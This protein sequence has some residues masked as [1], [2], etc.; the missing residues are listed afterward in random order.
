MADYNCYA[1]RMPVYGPA[2]RLISS[3]T[4]STAATVTTTFDHNYVDGTIVRFD[5]PPACGMQQID[6]Q[7]A[8]ILVTGATTFTVPIDT[9]MY[10]SFSVPSGLGPFVNI[11]A[12][13]VPLGEQNDTLK[14]AVVNQL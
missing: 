7:T 1:Y 11:C 8:P 14:A 5:I 3:I 4:N 6:Q 10:A 9:T 13:C 2:M 12:Q